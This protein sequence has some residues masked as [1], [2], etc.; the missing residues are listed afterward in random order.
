MK[1]KHTIQLAFFLLSISIANAQNGFSGSNATSCGTTEIMNRFFQKNPKYRQLDQ[2]IEQQ[3][4]NYYKS[5]R[6]ILRTQS[7]VTLPVVVHIIHNNG[8]E[9][10]SDARVLAGIQHLNEAF[11]NTGYYNPADGVNTNIQFCM[12]QRDPGGCLLY[13]SDAADE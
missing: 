4:L 8:P 1:Y 9:N 13:T 10:I 5:G 7:V 6:K 12:A 2:Q 3:L 11:A